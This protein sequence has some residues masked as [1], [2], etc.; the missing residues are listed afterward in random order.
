MR[1][2]SS[3]HTERKAFQDAAKVS[4]VTRSWE[5]RHEQPFTLG[6]ETEDIHGS[7]AKTVPVAVTS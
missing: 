2:S 3:V 5:E 4:I 6:K 7:S 1:I